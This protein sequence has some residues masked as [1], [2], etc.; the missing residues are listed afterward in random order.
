MWFSLEWCF[1]FSKPQKGVPLLSKKR[2]PITP[3]FVEGAEW[4]R[5]SSSLLGSL[6]KRPVWTEDQ[7]PREKKEQG[8]KGRPEKK[9]KK[10]KK[11]KTAVLPRP[12]TFQQLGCEKRKATWA[13]HFVSA[14]HTQFTSHLSASHDS[15]QMQLVRGFWYSLGFTHSNWPL[16]KCLFPNWKMAPGSVR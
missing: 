7:K 6:G 13:T 1:F 8:N 4:F 5:E 15:G 2:Q 10:K 3:V 14:Y 11:K 12:E 16:G 9:K